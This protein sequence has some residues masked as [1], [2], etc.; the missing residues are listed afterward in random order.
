M[1][2]KNNL[3]EPVID[4]RK[5]KPQMQMTHTEHDI[6]YEKAFVPREE[7]SHSEYALNTTAWD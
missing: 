5:D 2:N 7:I 4:F 1:D 6:L 3:Y